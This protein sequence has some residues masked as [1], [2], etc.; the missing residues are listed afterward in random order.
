VTTKH[1]V[2][3][4]TIGH[5]FFNLG[6]QRLET[7]VSVTDVSLGFIWHREGRPKAKGPPAIAIGPTELFR[8]DT[9]REDPGLDGILSH[10]IYK[11][12]IAVDDDGEEK[13]G[14]RLVPGISSQ[15][16]VVAACGNLMQGR[17]VGDDER[18]ESVLGVRSAVV[19]KVG[20][21]AEQLDVR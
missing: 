10:F 7:P 16:L 12:R 9:E 5:A 6:Q 1:E 3:D 19:D 21:V 15:E 17:A 8:E 2:N 18:F 13:A 14:A 20:L 11:C 4:N